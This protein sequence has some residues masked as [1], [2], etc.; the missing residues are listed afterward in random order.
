MYVH[1]LQSKVRGY[2]TYSVVYILEKV[3][4]FY[5]HIPLPPKPIRSKMV[6]N[7]RKFSHD[8]YKFPNSL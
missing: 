8:N 6:P 1:C 5:K 7:N 2:N 4:K 3:R